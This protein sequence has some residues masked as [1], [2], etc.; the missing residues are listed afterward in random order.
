MAAGVMLTGCGSSG[1]STESSAV[2]TPPVESASGSGAPASAEECPA[3]SPVRGRLKGDVSPLSYNGVFGHVYNN[4]GSTVWIWS[5]DRAATSPCRLSPGKG[6]SY[7]GPSQPRMTED[8]AWVPG[9]AR[10]LFWLLLT[11]S[12]DSGAPGTAVAV[13]DPPVGYPDAVSVYTTAGGSRC[14]RDDVRLETG[15][16]SEGQ[17]YRLKGNSQGSV[18]VKRLDDNEGIAREWMQTSD[19]DDWARMDLFVESIGRC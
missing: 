2:P 16:L 3:N 13:Y 19:A 11:S 12:Q 4:T 8:A 17:E 9:G 15:G 6:A 1:Q 14:D 7:G 10:G 5:Q 18:L